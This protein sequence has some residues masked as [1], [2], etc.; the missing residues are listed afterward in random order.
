MFHDGFLVWVGR[1]LGGKGGGGF[2]KQAVEVG[3]ALL[4]DG[5]QVG[6]PQLGEKFGGVANVG[7]FVGFAAVWYGG[8]VGGIGFD[9]EAVGGN[10]L[11]DF[12]DLFGVFEGNDA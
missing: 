3:A 8:E 9:Q 6:L 5:G 2:G 10:V 4:G 12:L 1:G 11:G 7:G